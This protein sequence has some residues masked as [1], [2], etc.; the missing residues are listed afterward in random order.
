M[1]NGFS[2]STYIISY[3]GGWD[4][5]R[6]AHAKQ[7]D[8]LEQYDIP[9]LVLAQGYKDADCDNRCRYVFSEPLG[10]PGKARNVLLERFYQ[11]EFDLGLFMDDDSILTSHCD[12]GKFI[13]L[14]LSI[15]KS[16]FKDVKMFVPI[17]P[18]QQPFN[19]DH[20][21]RHDIYA[22]YLHFHRH[23]NVNSSIFF[24]QNLR[25]LGFDEVYFDEEFKA[26]CDD[27]EFAMQVAYS[28]V[29]VYRCSNIVLSELENKTTTLNFGGRTRSEAHRKEK[30][31]LVRKWGKYGMRFN[32]DGSTL[33]RTVFLKHYFKGPM[34]VY[35][36]KP[37][38][39]AS[40][41]ES[42]GYLF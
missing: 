17:D 2:V 24:L 29:G 34:D 33:N 3:F 26:P 16:L 27:A 37:G 15:D 21:E 10:F 8:W 41:F 12:G 28:G 40:F 36:P 38:V 32:E 20:K 25:K 4:R 30:G 5:R 31:R 22:K 35:I 19:K 42:Q 13:N 18:R 9:I 39:T 14:L 11:S 7:L 1:S 23:L 6:E